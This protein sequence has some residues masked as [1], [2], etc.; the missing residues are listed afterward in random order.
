MLSRSIV[1][2]NLAVELRRGMHTG[3]ITVYDLCQPG[4]ALIC[5]EVKRRCLDICVAKIDPLE[6]LRLQLRPLG[7]LL[8]HW[9]YR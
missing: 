5:H 4:N 3:N 7:R 1:V 9:L 2:E 8:R 6:V